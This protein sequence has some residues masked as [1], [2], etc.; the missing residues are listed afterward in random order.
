MIKGKL[1]NQQE[2][3]DHSLKDGSPVLCTPS[4]VKIKGLTHLSARCRGF[5]SSIVVKRPRKVL[6]REV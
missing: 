4:S 1:K 5:G 2:V 3:V 6:D